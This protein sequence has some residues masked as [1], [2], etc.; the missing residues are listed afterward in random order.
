[1]PDGEP[2]AG[3]GPRE[4]I[5]AAAAA[6]LESGG[7]D[8]VS[9][10]AVSAAAG[11]QAPTIYRLFGDKQGLLHAVATDGFTRYL[12]T[13]T[14]RTPCKDPVDD[15]RAGWDLH[16]DLGLAHPALYGLLYDEH[17]AATAAPSGRAG[18]DVLAAKVHRIAAAGRLRV[19]EQRAVQLVQAAGHGLTLSLI[20]QP[21]GERDPALSHTAR[22][23]VIAAITTDAP[24]PSPPDPAAA[25]VNATATL[26]ALLPH[27]HDLTD[28][29]RALM[30]EWLDR[31]A[32][33]TP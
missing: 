19:P 31:I 21:A 15:L 32:R 26:R 27:T 3:G 8:A 25:L 5:V 2:A 16:V 18:A 29:E 11:V 23:A 4:R 22:E 7:R 28:A 14:D 24:R 1:M 30:H 20:T 10:R 33:H 12:A 17:R 13:K 9:T 6:L